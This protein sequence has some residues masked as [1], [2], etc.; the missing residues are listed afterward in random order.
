MK[1]DSEARVSVTP[2]DQEVEVL[3]LELHCTL[4]HL[5]LKKLKR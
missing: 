1:E 3:H 5:K 4:F 2:A